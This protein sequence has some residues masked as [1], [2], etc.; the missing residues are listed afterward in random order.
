MTIAVHG[1]VFDQ[2]SKPYILQVLNLVAEKGHQL[3]L[4]ETLKNSDLGDDLQPYSSYTDLSVIAA[5]FVI[6]LGGDGTF[7]ETVTH[8]GPAQ[9]PV[10]GINTGRLGFLASI[11]REHIG[12]AI[13]A[14]FREEFQIEHR[15]LLSLETPQ[16]LFGAENYALNE[17]AI[18]R[19]DTSS[20][21]VINCFLDGEF[22]NTYW[23][24]GLMVSTPTGSTGY[25]LSCGGPLVMPHSKNFII[26]PV[27]PHNLNVRPLIISEDSELTFTV[28]SREKSYLVSL[29]S[30]SVAVDHE[31]NLMIKKTSFDLKLVKII[32]NSF[33]ETLRNKLSWGL[34]KRN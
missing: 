9:I 27:S 13:D 8:V 5:D 19:K 11:A 30:R 23:A 2:E 6:S 34:D 31:I 29:D 12:E 15:S 28:E 33:L 22:L 3:F 25:N 18:L 4:S 32:G 21:I 14:L 7:L 20:M 17:F 24:D 26:T 1:R 16:P 10:L